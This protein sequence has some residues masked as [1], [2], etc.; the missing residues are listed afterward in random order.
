LFEYLREK[1]TAYMDKM[2]EFVFDE[3]GVELSDCTLFCTL[4]AAKWTQKVAGKHAKERNEALQAAFYNITWYWD[5]VQVVAID[6]SV[7]NEWTADRKGGWG[8]ASEPI[9]LPYLVSELDVN[10]DVH[11]AWSYDY[12]CLGVNR[13]GG[14]SSSPL[15]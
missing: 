7:A 10:S 5:P 13:E 3:Y 2:I 9:I 4:E 6:K 12:Y 1:P 15:E 14:R 11:L 8:P